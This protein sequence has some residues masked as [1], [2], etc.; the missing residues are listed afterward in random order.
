VKRFR[1]FTHKDVEAGSYR[2]W[3]HLRRR[4]DRELGCLSVELTTNRHGFA[5]IG[6]TLNDDDRDVMLALAIP[7]V[8]AIWIGIEIKPLGFNWSSH[9]PL[10]HLFVRGWPEHAGGTGIRPGL[11]GWGEREFELSASRGQLRLSLGTMPH[12]GSGNR[13][14]LRRRFP[15]EW[16]RDVIR[17]GTI[18]RT[19]RHRRAEPTG[20]YRR[21]LR[22]RSWLPE[23]G[24]E[25]T[26]LRYDWR[27]Q[28]VGRKERL[29]ST[30]V[31]D[32]TFALVPMPEGNYP[33][34]VTL[35][36]ETWGRKRW[37]WTRT[38]QTRADIEMHVPVPHP[39]K[40]EN[41][42]DCDDDALYSMCGPFGSIGAA[43][44]AVAGSVMRSRERY[45]NGQAWTP[46]DGWPDG[47]I[48]RMIDAPGVAI[49]VTMPKPGE[50]VA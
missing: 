49:G 13:L 8:F 14:Y 47:M 6:F 41:S 31:E 26:L 2:R 17:T 33:C 23:H 37:P 19:D 3:W 1:V 20:L 11:L 48:L 25:I 46:S 12:G 15:R 36:R 30:T 43:T 7:K 27:D 16:V 21:Y 28:V 4:G 40:G 38:T 10:R 44:T 24:F 34:T 29:R 45:G 35:E 5:H 22:W 32:R 50:G 18:T 42:W 39:G 9:N